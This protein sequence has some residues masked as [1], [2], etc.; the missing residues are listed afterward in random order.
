VKASY[1]G[2]LIAFEIQLSTTFLSVIVERREFYLKNNALIFW[3]FND[4]DPKNTKITQEDIFYNNNGNIFIIDNETVAKSKE[5]QA[6]HVCCM[7]M[8]SKGEPQKV[9]WDS[10]IVAFKDLT[11]DFKKQRA[12]YFDLERNDISAQKKRARQEFLEWYEKEKKGKSGNEIND[13]FYD[14]L[15][16]WIAKFRGYGIDIPEKIDDRIIAVLLSA[17]QGEPIGFNF[18]KIVQ[19]ANNMLMPTASLISKMYSI[20]DN[21]LEFYHSN[22]ELWSDYLKWLSEKNHNRNEL[23]KD[24]RF[25]LDKQYD[26]LI[27]FLFPELIGILEKMNALNTDIR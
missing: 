6:F 22:N 4:F 10:S 7:W 5:K 9:D 16:K 18:K 24:R 3:I 26:E 19:I 17:K 2:K 27:I 25:S 14:E 20:F 8:R 21:A 12:F 23:K 11:L 13:S 1:C 15:E